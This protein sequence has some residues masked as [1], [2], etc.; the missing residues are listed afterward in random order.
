MPLYYFHLST[1]AL[2]P[3]AREKL[4]GLKAAKS[5]ASE[6]ARDFAK[7]RAT[8][9]L[10]NKSIIVTDDT[11]HVVIRVPLLKAISELLKSTG[12]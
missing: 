12:R 5:V 6:I 10:G 3:E 2:I 1:D 11:G 8:S 9:K 4:A 7:N